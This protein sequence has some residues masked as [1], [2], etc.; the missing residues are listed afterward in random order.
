MDKSAGFD[1]VAD[2]YDVLAGLIFGKAII[3]SQTIFLGFIPENS[4]ILVLGGGSG[5]WL[6]ELLQR[7]PNCSVVFIDPS[8]RMLDLAKRNVKND[9]RV[10]F[11][12]GTENSIIEKSA[13]DVVITFFFLDMFSGPELNVLLRKLIITLKPDG[14]GLVTD[15]VDTKWWHKI[16]LSTMYIFFRMVSGLG[17]QKLVDWSVSLKDA[18]ALEVADR[19]FYGDFIKSAV[20]KFRPSGVA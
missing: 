3:L 15:F 8:A 2:Y 11:V 5:W 9:A 18:G 20:F 1:S 6:P 14:I 17:N 16:F 7:K 10:S 4:R 13:Y 12:C 19:Y